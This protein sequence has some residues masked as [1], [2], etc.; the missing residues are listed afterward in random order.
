MEIQWISDSLRDLKTPSGLDSRTDTGFGDWRPTRSLRCSG[1]RRRERAD[2]T[3][4]IPKKGRSFDGASGFID[5][6]P[7]ASSCWI[8]QNLALRSKCGA[9]RN[10]IAT[11]IATRQ[12]RHLGAVRGTSRSP[13]D[14]RRRP[15]SSWSRTR[16]QP[17]CRVLQ[18]FANY[19]YSAGFFIF[20]MTSRLSDLHRI[21]PSCRLS[22]HEKGKKRAK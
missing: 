11:R 10:E 21:V 14:A 2:I 5:F 7:P 22:L 3:T 19:P 1:V 15:P 20:S 8:P 4:E 13:F 16:E 17:F 6:A 12:L 9:I 18:V